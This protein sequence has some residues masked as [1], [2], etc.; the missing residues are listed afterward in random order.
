MEKE[1]KPVSTNDP[2]IRQLPE[3]TADIIHGKIKGEIPFS[4]VNNSNLTQKQSSNT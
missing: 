4:P 3:E 1:A 2:R